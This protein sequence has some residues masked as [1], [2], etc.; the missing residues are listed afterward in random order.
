MNNNRE[1]KNKRFES[2]PRPT[3]SDN[4]Q[5]NQPEYID[6][7]S[8]KNRETDDNAPSTKTSSPTGTDNDKQKP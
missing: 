8:D 6:D 4:Q 3:E 1:D 7:L 2:Y 5:K